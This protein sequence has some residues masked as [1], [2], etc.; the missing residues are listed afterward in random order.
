MM[1]SLKEKAYAPSLR[2]GRAVHCGLWW[3]VM[4]SAEAGSG[5]AETKKSLA[6]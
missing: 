3:Y 2:K 5:A 1:V 6:L 4:S